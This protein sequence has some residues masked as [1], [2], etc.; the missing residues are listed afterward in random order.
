MFNKIV[1]VEPVYI[2]KEGLIELKKH[3]IE[4]QNK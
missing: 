1:V 2:K 3:W 4:R